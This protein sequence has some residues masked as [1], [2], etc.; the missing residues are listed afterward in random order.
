MTVVTDYTALLY[1]PSYAPGRW[2]AQAD[3]GTQTIVT[4]SFTDLADLQSLEDYDPYGATSYWSYSETQRTLFREVIA[5]YEEVAGVK[6]VEVQ[7]SSMINVF[8]AEVSGVGGWAN[9]PFSTTY[10]DNP[11]GN[12]NFVNAYQ[13]MGEGDYGY[14]VNLHELGHAMG[15]QHPHEGDLTLDPTLDTQANTVMTYNI[16]NP[17]VTELG[18]FDIQAMQHIYGTAD[19]I[20]NWRVSVDANDLITIKSS[21][22]AEVVL[23]TDQDNLIFTYAG[24]DE[25]IGREGNDKVFSGGGSD[26]VTGAK[27]DDSLY[28]GAGEDTLYGGDDDDSLFGGADDDYLDGGN[29]TDRLFGSGG[30]DTILGGND[31]DFVVGGD[32]ADLLYG[33]IDANPYSGNATSHDRVSGNNGND[34]I[35]G[36]EGNDY[37]I[38]GNDDDLVEG[39]YGNDTLI[40][41]SGNDT[42]RGG[43]GSDRMFGGGGSDTFV[44]D[45]ADA[46]EKDYIFGFEFNSD[47]I[48]IS[49]IGFTSI[50]QLT[51]TQRG[52]HTDIS[53]S[54]WFEITLASRDAS[55]LDA[56]DFVFA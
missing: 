26:T 36:G 3:I 41:N 44:F 51:I 55:L 9:I 52:A 46:N 14:Q 42:L 2:N 5:K 47:L 29:G 15:L 54:D 53:Y 17:Y 45:G 20:D 43:D 37:L 21:N 22:Q 34:T 6:F 16:E 30:N 56:N 48:D 7:G 1:Y 19:Q 10:G 12:G 28:G 40:G 13:N 39:G 49:A 50:N 8:G 24:D 31:D 11:T 18:I 27:G 35:Y 4:Y 25:V 33:D 23:A 38:G 32:G